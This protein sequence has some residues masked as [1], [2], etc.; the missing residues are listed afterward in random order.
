MHLLDHLRLLRRYLIEYRAS[1][2]HGALRRPPATGEQRGHQRERG[3]PVHD[4]RGL[5][6]SAWL[7][8][9]DY[10]ASANPLIDFTLDP[11]D[12]AVAD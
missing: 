6:V 10:R 3:Q 2:S 12:D 1:F 5:A 11:T 7:V 4:L 8:V 9:A